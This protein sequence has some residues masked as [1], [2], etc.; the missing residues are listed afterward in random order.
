MICSRDGTGEGRGPEKVS[1]EAGRKQGRGI[2][3]LPLLAAAPIIAAM[4]AA[5]IRFWPEVH[6]LLNIMIKLVVRA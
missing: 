3:F 4:A 2:Y 6:K 5:V 1:T